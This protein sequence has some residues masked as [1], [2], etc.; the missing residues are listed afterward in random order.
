MAGR[1]LLRLRLMFQVA[2]AARYRDLPIPSDE[3]LLVEEFVREWDD[4]SSD[5]PEAAQSLDRFARGMLHVFAFRVASR[6][7]RERQVEY[8]RLGLSALRIAGSE[9]DPRDLQ[10]EACVLFDSCMKI[11]VE[12][13]FIFREAL[14]E[15]QGGAAQILQAFG[16]LPKSEVSLAKY[17]VR[18]ASDD[19]GFRYKLGLS[20]AA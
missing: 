11:G 4:S 17:R 16:Q 5:T 14:A 2:A 6:A 10:Q 19:A 1:D 12:P 3:D 7:V 20:G 18:E 13:A 8:I 15:A 9:D